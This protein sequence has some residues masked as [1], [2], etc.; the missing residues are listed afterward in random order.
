MIFFLLRS[1]SKRNSAPSPRS[2]RLRGELLFGAFT[3]ETPSALRLRR[4]NPFFLQIPGGAVE[5]RRSL[6]T[7]V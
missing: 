3:A 4:E 6:I 5:R 1:L 2:R 7:S